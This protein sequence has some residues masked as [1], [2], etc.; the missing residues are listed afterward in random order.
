L[1]L[2]NSLWSRI[3]LATLALA[4]ILLLTLTACGPR[5]FESNG[6]RIYFTGTSD[7]GDRISYVDDPDHMV[8]MGRLTCAACHGDNGRGGQVRIMMQ[9][10][11]APNITWAELTEEHHGNGEVEHPPY[12]E[13]TLG[14]A[15]TQGLDPAGR[16]LGSLMPRWR[17]SD[18]DLDDLIAY[19]K[20]LEGN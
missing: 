4:V 16:P 18:R 10:F 14:R 11:E 12:N 7:S 15:I 3:Y 6:E 20:T 5:R 17:M 2:E 1:A 9:R 13:V 8:G 19:L